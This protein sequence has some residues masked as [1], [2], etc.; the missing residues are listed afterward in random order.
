MSINN[1]TI[2]LANIFITLSGVPIY[3]NLI[4]LTLKSKHNNSFLLGI[5]SSS[6]YINRYPLLYLL[7]IL[8][9]S[10]VCTS[11]YLLSDRMCNTKKLCLKAKAFKHSLLIPFFKNTY[12]ICLI[13]LF[14]KNM[15]TFFI[16]CTIIV[17]N[18]STR[19]TRHHNMQSL[20]IIIINICCIL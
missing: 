6:S 13:H 18:I 4:H 1:L 14:S 2:S 16:K 12:I 9:L 15:S 8:Y 10:Y 19:L 20:I 11:F 17:N 5:L 7:N 3:N